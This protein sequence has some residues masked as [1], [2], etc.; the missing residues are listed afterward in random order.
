MRRRHATALAVKAKTKNMAKSSALRQRRMD[1]W[2]SPI[3]EIC[4]SMDSTTEKLL[5][6]LHLNSRDMN[7][8]FDS[9]RS[10]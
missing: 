8:P 2:N 3:N 1:N 9:S 7:R 10:N 6:S 4:A 5:R